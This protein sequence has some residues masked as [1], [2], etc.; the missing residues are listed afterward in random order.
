M[1][2]KISG[3]IILPLMVAGFL[4]AAEE[5]HADAELMILLDASSSMS[6]PGTPGTQTTKFREVQNAIVQLLQELPPE[7]SVGLR[8]VGGSQTA[9]CYYSYRFFAPTRGMRSY[10]RDQLENIIPG[11]ERG[12]YQ[13]IQ[14]GLDDLISVRS[15]V[16]KVLLV[17]T[18]GGDAC[19]RNFSILAGSYG[20]RSGDIR[21][22]I[23]G[24]ELPNSV[25]TELGDFIGE[26]GGRL[27]SFDSTAALSQA[28]A[29]FAREFENNLVI[30][31]QDST[32]QAVSGDVI[33]KDTMT[34]LVVAEKLNVT[35]ASLSVPP[36]SYQVVGRYY[37]QEVQSDRFSIAINESRSVSITFSVSREPV[38]VV[39][40]DV[41]GNALR[42]RLTFYTLSNE[43]I[44]TTDF[45]STHYISLPEGSYYA[46]ARVGDSVHNIYGIQ[47]GPGFDEVIN[48]ELPVEL[49]VL[50]IDVNN[51]EGIPVNAKITVTNQDGTVVEQTQYASS[52]Y[53]RLPAGTY[54]V[55]VDIGSRTYQETAYL[56]EGDQMQMGFDVDMP[57]GDLYVKLETETGYDVWGIVKIYDDK[58]NLLERFY[59]E[60]WESPDWFISDL[61]I[62]IYRIQ[63]IADNVVRVVSGV[64]IRANEETEVRVIF[65]DEVF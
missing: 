36:G 41:Y 62:G 28:L 40:R 43:P 12:L 32:G 59:A 27:V 11:G 3:L 26:V 7:V 29:G 5:A 18:D 39:L 44:L 50:E 31:L 63:A 16:D 6:A 51:N 46:E 58:G 4:F 20:Y 23:Y 64:E 25:K 1:L 65:P 42:A 13:G 56:Y 19:D 17:I 8:I 45:G 9:D 35:E 24:L 38:T 60:D 30:Y 2:K 48:L 21:V 54:R 49:G 10:I 61:P 22:L 33:V 34:N 57:V 47:V 37:G 53:A 52:L 55:T 14:D 15:R